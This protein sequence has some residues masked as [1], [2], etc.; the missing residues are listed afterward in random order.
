MCTS[1]GEAEQR[2]S[3]DVDCPAG[4]SPQSLDRPHPVLMPVKRSFVSSL[5]VYYGHG[6]ESSAGVF[7]FHPVSV[8]P[9]RHSAGPQLRHR[10]LFSVEHQ[11]Q[12]LGWNT[13]VVLIN[14]L[15]VFI[16]YAK[17]RRG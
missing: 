14:L 13:L 9:S 8:A 7:S 1:G 16:H 10:R 6:T 15:S 17:S 12:S 3:L 2:E 11:A 4:F 5:L